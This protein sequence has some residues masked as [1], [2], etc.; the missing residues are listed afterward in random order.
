MPPNPPQESSVEDLVHRAQA[1]DRAALEVLFSRHLV[2]I[3]RIAERRLGP[4]LRRDLDAADIVQDS[5]AVALRKLPGFRLQGEGSFLHWMGSIVEHQITDRSAW[6][7]AKSRDHAREVAMD[8]GGSDDRPARPVRQVADEDPTPLQEAVLHEARDLVV[9]SLAALDPPHR[10]VLLLREYEGLS[11][12]DIASRTG[13]ASPDAARMFHARAL[14]LLGA[15]MQS[16]P[17][18]TVNGAVRTRGR[19]PGRNAPRNGPAGPGPVRA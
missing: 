9:E 19:A 10:Q 4:G 16:H 14:E 3:R 12:E 18:T 5:L 11:W 15:R 7:H 13:H 17:S 2:R 8:A 1:G 6:Q